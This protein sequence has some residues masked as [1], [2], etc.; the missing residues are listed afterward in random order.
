VSLPVI[1]RPLAETDIVG[2]RADLD[3]A[4]AGL[5]DRF[6]DQLADLLEQI[7]FMPELFGLT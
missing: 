4:Q 1:I 5:G 3:T 6:A 7:E 2:I